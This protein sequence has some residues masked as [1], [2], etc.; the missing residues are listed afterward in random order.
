MPPTTFMSTVAPC[1]GALAVL[2]TCAVVAGLSG[3]GRDLGS[4]DQNAASELVYGRN[5]LVATKGQALMHDSCGNAAFCH[6]AAANGGK[7]F[8]A[9]AGLNFDMMP[10]TGWPE[11]VEHRDDIWSAVSDGTMPPGSKGGG[12]LGDGDWVFDVQRPKGAEKLPALSTREGQGAFRNW[13]AC[14]APVVGNV[15]VPSWA[16]PAGD[17][18]DGGVEPDGAPTWTRVHE[19]VLVP[20][21]A[22]AGCHAGASAKN[23]GMLDMSNLC[24]ARAALFQKGPCGEPR[25]RAGRA[26]SLL[27]DKL[28]SVK[29]RCMGRMPP[30]LGGL[31]AAS[32]DLVRAWVVAGAPAPECP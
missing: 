19:E 22:I 21:C 30:P 12:T 13:L 2:L 32:I 3:C 15:H 24:A 7:R 6:S 4:C 23:S 17:D 27:V 18:D 20:S 29:P 26:D 11:L 8:G 28:E 25:V 1:R 5:G 31:P 16:E 14:G 10:P 9:P